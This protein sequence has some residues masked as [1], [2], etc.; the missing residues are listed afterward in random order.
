MTAES[1]ILVLWQ[2]VWTELL[3]YL[4]R[5]SVQAQLLVAL[6]VLSVT[7]GASRR[8]QAWW[9]H[10]ADPGEGQATLK[11][12][13]LYQV[14]HHMTPGIVALILLQMG[15]T[16]LVLWG[17]RGGLL[18]A[19]LRIVVLYLMLKILLAV[20]FALGDGDGMRRYQGTLIIP[21]FTVVLG[22]QLLDVFFHN[23]QLW[24][25]PIFVMF[26]SPITLS[27][28]FLVTVGFYLWVVGIHAVGQ[29]IHYMATR[30]AGA[31][32]GTT[33]AMLTLLRYLL[34]IVGLGYVLFRLNFD[35]TT[36]AAISGGLSVGVGFAL[37]TILSN[38]A[39]GVLL[40]F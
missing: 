1:N 25:T 15:K 16:V 33:Q 7:I 18:D 26:D 38:F 2:E 9:Q 14:V 35:T 39:S 8:L 34:I 10:V 20:A 32:V 28:L 40:L 5:P 19:L 3:V 23:R 11:R 22:G 24:A 37:S 13:L 4:G 6:V 30:Y 31:D 17:T 29:G 12:R 36:I 21:L 27:G